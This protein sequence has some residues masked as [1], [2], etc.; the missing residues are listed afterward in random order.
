MK[1]RAA[2][3]RHRTREVRVEGRLNLDG[4][5]RAS[6]S[7]GIAFL[8]HMLSLWAGHG[9]FDLTLKARGD[10]EVD[11]HH[12]NEDVGLA[13]GEAFARALGNK[14]GIRRMGSAFVPMDE[15]LA[16]ARAVA[17]IS[18]R[19]HL[20]WRWKGRARSA[21]AGYEAK[22]A[23]H[24]LEGFAA[25]AGLTLHVDLLKSGQDLHHQLEAVFKALG[26]A[27][28]EAVERDPRVKGIPSTKGKL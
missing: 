7:T 19:P 8:D 25:K 26:R 20:S 2:A 5:G 18:G 1:K 22:D 28:R 9:L 10:L 24:L 6:V 16:R 3:V 23:R 21:G 17:D 11:I 15:T 4:R 27:L 13:L 14:R 12:T